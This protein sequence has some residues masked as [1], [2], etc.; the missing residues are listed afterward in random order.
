MSRF[1]SLYYFN[2]SVTHTTGKAATTSQA[3]LTGYS[4][5]GLNWCKNKFSNLIFTKYC[6]HVKRISSC[7]LTTWVL[8]LFD[9]VSPLPASWLLTS[10]LRPLREGVVWEAREHGEHFD[11][12][13]WHFSLVVC[14]ANKRQWSAGKNIYKSRSILNSSR[15]QN[16][17]PTCQSCLLS[18]TVYNTSQNLCFL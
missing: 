18:I 2:H 8:F 3:K 4:N 10:Q 9:N 11:Q 17:I 5:V 7:K 14:A 12:C 16:H 6:D 15:S 1:W 13:D